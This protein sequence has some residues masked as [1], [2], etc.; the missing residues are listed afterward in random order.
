MQEKAQNIYFEAG[1]VRKKGIWVY[2]YWNSV[3]E[4]ERVIISTPLETKINIFLTPS[5]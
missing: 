5:Y 4:T 2:R 1:Q 3:P